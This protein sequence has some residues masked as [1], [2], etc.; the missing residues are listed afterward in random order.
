M[1][2]QEDI[3]FHYDVANDFYAMFLYQWHRAYSCGVWKAATTLEEAQTAKLDRLCRYANISAGSH[4]LDVGCG[5]GGLLRHAI[6]AFG[7]SS[8]HGLTLSTDQFNYVQTIDSSHVS[9]ELSSWADFTPVSRAYDSIVSIGAFEHFASMEDRRLRRHREVY[10][11]FLN[12]VGEFPL[13]KLTL[14]CRQLSPLDHRL[15]LAKSVIRDT[16]W[17]ASSRDLRCR[18]SVIYRPRL[19]I[20]MRYRRASA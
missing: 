11:R 6:S 9:V 17:S 8:A 13:R 15:I 4:V 1:A 2:T 16:F 7:A 19:W 12:G 18:P 3:S 14:V 10:R 20:Y 5:W